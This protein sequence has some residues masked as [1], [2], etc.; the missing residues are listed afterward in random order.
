MLGKVKSGIWELEPS[1]CALCGKEAY[2]WDNDWVYIEETGLCAECLEK[3]TLL[4][5]NCKWRK[6]C[7]CYRFKELGHEVPECYEPFSEADWEKEF[8]ER[9]FYD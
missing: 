1:K 2:L 3:A 6:Y 5:A 8:E 4:T 9:G 7:G